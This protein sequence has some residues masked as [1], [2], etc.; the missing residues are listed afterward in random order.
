MGASSAS[1]YGSL[2]CEEM[3]RFALPVED[4]AHL[5][6]WTTNAF[7]VEAHALARAWGFV[8]KTILTWTKIR[9]DGRPSMK[10]GHYYRGATEHC[11]F[12]V[13]G[14]LKLRGPAAPT[15]FLTGRLPHSQKPDVFY[16]TV[17][18]QSPGPYL[19]MFARRPRAGWSVWGNEVASDV[20]IGGREIRNP[21]P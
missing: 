17:R 14:R 13:R 10:M 20:A 6:L 15:A 4:D 1:R 9:R 11:V 21:A 16:R 18:E 12:A 3:E 19:E 7:M 2:S 5:Y 8:P